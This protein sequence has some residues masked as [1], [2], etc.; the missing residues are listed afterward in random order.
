[1]KKKITSCSVVALG[2]SLM[3]GVVL[4]DGEGG[5]PSPSNN[6]QTSSFSW[7]PYISTSPYAGPNAD[8]RITAYDASDVWSQQSSMNEDLTVLKY[9][10][11]LQ[12]NLQKVGLSLDQRPIVE[13]S[14]GVAGTATQTFIDFN[15]AKNNGDFGLST[16]EIDVNAMV[17]EWATGFMSLGYNS[18]NSDVFVSRGFVTIGNLNKSPFY[19]TAGQVY[20]PFG[21]YYSGL[22]T[23]P[24]TLSLARIK[25][26]AVILGYAKDNFSMQGFTYPGIDG[27]ANGAMFHG[28]GFNTNYKMIFSPSINVNV[29]G[30][31]IS[32]MTGAS[33]MQS[34]GASSPQFPGF[35]SFSG[36][37]TYSFVHTVPGAGAHA[38]FN[39]WTNTLAVEFIGAA[40]KFDAQDLSYNG[41]GA[42]PEALHVE[43]L[44]NFKIQDHPSTVGV[45]Y[46]RSWQ[47]LGLSLPQSSYMAYFLTSLWKNTLQEIEF[48]HDA[49][50]SSSNIATAVSNPDGNSILGPF[51]NIGTGKSR[52]MVTLQFGVYF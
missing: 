29:G 4:A 16:A 20:L 9:K 48:R 11:T 45:A 14:G 3:T 52:D 47:A 35:T 42:Q 12:N 50:Y 43:L 21:R 22:N 36:D 31:V 1:M 8:K 15:G 51:T 18:S 17:G 41:N 33:G 24:L 28:G 46:G 5:A 32:D 37:S 25:D 26:Q 30:S 38:E 10:Q 13:I 34:T 40:R 44:R 19:L 49:D 2:L 6:P 7:I 23:A 27:N 39:F